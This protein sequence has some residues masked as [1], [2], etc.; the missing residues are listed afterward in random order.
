MN[1]GHV[2]VEDARDAMVANHQMARSTNV[3]RLSM[4][5]PVYH[6][7][8]MELIS[9]IDSA[10]T[11]ACAKVSLNV[12]Q[13]IDEVYTLEGTLRE[14]SSMTF[15]LVPNKGLRRNLKGRPQSSR[16]HNGM[17]IREKSDGKLCGVYKLA[18]Y[19]RSKCL[20]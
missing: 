2:F 1:A 10:I 17:A 14:V 15:E 5:D 4:V 11:R 6:L 3:E 18:D 19:N 12:E 7:G 8:P 9:E 20:L 16:I 13:F